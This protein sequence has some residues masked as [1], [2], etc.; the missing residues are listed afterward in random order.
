MLSTLQNFVIVIVSVVCSVLM[1]F[2]L[3]KL[4]PSEKRQVH[5]DLIGWQL[6]ILGTTYAVIIGFMLY[7]VWSNFGAAELNADA[8]ANADVNIYRLAEG[9]PDQ[10]RE[11][12]RVL[13]RSYADIVVNQEWPE[14]ARREPAHASSEIAQQMWHILMSVKAAA[15]E[16]LTAEDHAL[17]ELS[18][19]SEHRRIRQLQ[20][21]SNL[22]AILWCVLLIGGGVTVVSACLFGQRNALLHGLQ[23]FA[24]SLLISLVLVAV[25]DI[26]RPFQGSVHVSDAAFRR[27]L[28][29]MSER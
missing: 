26:D 7:A 27:A 8:E 15:P 6:G 11:Q 22:P 13:A 24:F 17:Y 4:W 19:M 25:A 10:Q 29:N 28:Q 14:M 23:V 3:N 21:V 9:L 2:V 16:E 1:L 5:N 12:L 20:S 18:A